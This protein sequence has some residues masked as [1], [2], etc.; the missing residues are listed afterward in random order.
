MKTLLV[1]RHAKAERESDSGEDFDRPLAVRGWTDSRAIGREMRV[2]GIHPDAVVA[3]P[4][5]RVVE[6]LEAVAEGYGA[7]DVEFDRRIFD[8]RPESLLAILHGADDEVQR[9]L[10]VGHNPGLQEILLRL[11]TADAARLRDQIADKFPTAALAEMEL[12]V[13]N[14]RE[15]R[16]GAGRITRLVRPEDV[17]IDP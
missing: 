2:R 9:L 15:V 16:Q 17:G 6:T 3:S 11:A 10:I 12:P 14:W 5:R 1:L 4:A 8:N 13:G 7:L